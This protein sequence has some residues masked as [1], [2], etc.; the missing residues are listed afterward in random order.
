MNTFRNQ[1][2]GRTAFDTPERE[3]LSARA[4][5][6]ITGR[7]VVTPDPVRKA[8]EEL[9]ALAVSREFGLVLA[10]TMEYVD[11]RAEDERGQGPDSFA[12]HLAREVQAAVD[13]FPEDDVLL[14]Q[15]IRNL[16]RASRLMGEFTYRPT[17]AVRQDDPQVIELVSLV[18]HFKAVTTEHN[19]RAGTI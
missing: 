11:E 5:R 10:D 18:E 16:K 17:T 14:S 7:P 1:N 8:Q 15:E 4:W 2:E 3:R 12:M 19:R 6:L 13:F 9:R